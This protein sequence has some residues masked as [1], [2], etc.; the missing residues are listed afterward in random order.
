VTSPE[1]VAT[2]ARLE[3]LIH[4]PAQAGHDDDDDGVK[5]HLVRMTDVSDNVE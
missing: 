5:P 1:F 4:P 2:R 3:A